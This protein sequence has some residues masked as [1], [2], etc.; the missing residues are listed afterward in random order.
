[1]D[2]GRK[3]AKRVIRRAC[4]T[5]MLATADDGAAPLF[6]PTDLGKSSKVTLNGGSAKV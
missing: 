4:V 2:V 6:R 5:S 3:S 1:L